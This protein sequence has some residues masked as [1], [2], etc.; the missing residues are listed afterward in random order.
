MLSSFACCGFLAA[1]SAVALGD[2]GCASVDKVFADAGSK[3]TDQLAEL[4]SCGDAASCCAPSSVCDGTAGDVC[5][6]LL[7]EGCS[8]G[9]G[10]GLFGSG[11]SGISIG[12][13]IQGGYH[14]K[15]TQFSQVRNDGLAFN[16]RPNSFN[17]HQ[18]WLYAEKEADGSCGTDWGFRADFMYG[19]DAA[20]TQAFGNN[21]GR[22][23]FQNG[24]D[25]GDGYGWALPQLYA[26]I[27]SGDWSI[28]GGHFYTLV[29]YEVVTAPDN[30][31][32]S[33][34]FTMY[35]SEPFTHTGVLATYSASDDVTMYGGWTA[36]WDTGFDQLG[37]G[38][39]FLGGASFQLTD[40]ATATYITTIG[41]F[42]W[43]GEGYSHSVVIDTD[44]GDGVNWV[45]QSDVLDS[46][47]GGL[48][49]VGINNYLFYDLSDNMKAGSRV[50]WWKANGTSFHAATFGV[51]V[52]PADNLIIRPEIRYNWTPG[53][54]E[55]NVTVFG[56]DAIITF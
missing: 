48:D 11:G 20:S 24:W 22:W 14:N 38:S 47:P 10:D 55:P 3:L 8:D 46:G 41:N 23:D 39:S 9:C 34:A 52:A 32:Y 44:L 43:R 51:N 13:W 21:P 26:E 25:R 31:F 45:L 4:S 36:G 6:D 27:A 49:T 1:S 50:E 28:I 30:F 7:G 40:N 5:G 19:T 33:H 37:D 16:D 12:G 42:G 56:I 15:N 2:D 35:N 29:G 17:M 54:A 18:V 53:G